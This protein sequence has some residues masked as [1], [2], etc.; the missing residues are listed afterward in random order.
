M[1]YTVTGSAWRIDASKP[2][3]KGQ[4]SKIFSTSKGNFAKGE[5]ENN[6]KIKNKDKKTRN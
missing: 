5:T 6:N 3:G 1:G 2:L 4:S